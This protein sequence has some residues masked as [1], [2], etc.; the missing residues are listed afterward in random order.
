MS[1]TEYPPTSSPPARSSVSWFV[2][3]IALAWVCLIFLLPGNGSLP[4]IDRDEPRFA[5]ATREMMQRQDWIV[6]YFNQEY[7]FDKPPLIYWMMAAAYGAGGVNE[8]TARL[9]SVVCALL[10]GWSLYGM[11]RRWLQDDRKAFLAALMMLTCFQMLQHGRA[12]VADMPM[13]L[14]VFWSHAA[15][16]HLL[17]APGQAS[18][19]WFWILYGSLGFGFLAKGPVALAV[20]LLTILFFRVVFDRK[21]LPWRNLKL[22][23]GLAVVLALVGAWGIPALIMTRGEF[24]QVGIGKHVIERGHASFNGHMASAA[25]YLLTLAIS[26]FPW[27]ASLGVG[28]G[29]LRRNFHRDRLMRFLVAWVV[30]TYLLFSLYATK[31][32]HYVMPAFPAWMLLLADAIISRTSESKASV[33]WRRGVRGLF[34]TL[35]VILVFGGSALFFFVTSSTVSLAGLALIGLGLVLGGLLWLGLYDGTVSLARLWSPLLVCAAGVVLVGHSLHH[36][37]PAVA[38]ARFL[39]DLPPETQ[40]GFTGY[41]EPSVVFYTDRK[42]E[43]LRSED[44]PSFLGMP[45]SRALVIREREVKADRAFRQLFAPSRQADREQAG[46]VT[47]EELEALG[48]HVDVVEGINPARS[49]YVRLLVAKKTGP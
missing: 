25:F 45:G 44:L 28:F 10:L 11:G 39:S 18:R 19:R 32:P 22:L 46:P 9:P 20:P 34:G 42:W 3:A 23:P 33:W 6:P 15:L 4:L 27:S 17:L 38:A 36:A 14:C 43:T 41:T 47:R 35:A 30:G 1:R 40:C 16:V 49:S 48:Y 12:A 2:W 7:R 21:P 24:Y 5:Q 31:L 26:L 29:H 8:F 13:I 37:H